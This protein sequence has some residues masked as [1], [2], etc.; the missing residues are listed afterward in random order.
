L[1]A[2]RSIRFK[3][4]VNASI[5]YHKTPHSPP[6]RRSIQKGEEGVVFSG[7]YAPDEDPQED[8]V[9]KGLRLS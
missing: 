6:I 7:K 8:G 5:F 4:H 2:F 9:R 1:E 3:L